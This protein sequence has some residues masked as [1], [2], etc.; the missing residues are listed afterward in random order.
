MVQPPMSARHVTHVGGL[1]EVARVPGVDIVSLNRSPGPSVDW[2]DGTASH[3][4][5][6][7]GSVDDHEVLEKTVDAIRDALKIDYEP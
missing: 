2:K 1:E 6:V 4:V 3:V 7:R 5:T